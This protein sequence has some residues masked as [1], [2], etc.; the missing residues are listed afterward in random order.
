MLR[1]VALFA[2]VLVLLI[3]PVPAA[4][5]GGDDGRINPFG[6]LGAPVA[7]YYDGNITLYV[8]TPDSVGEYLFFVPAEDIEAAGIPAEGEDPIILWEDV[9]P[10]GGFDITISR[11]P[12]GEFRMDTRKD[13]AFNPPDD[14]EPYI[15]VWMTNRSDAYTLKH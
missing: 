2:V 13:A 10:Y 8:I 15:V 11:L 3:S 7:I 14:T 9:N 12:T 5:Q 6:G 1:K 4:A